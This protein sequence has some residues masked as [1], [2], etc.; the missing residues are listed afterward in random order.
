MP[1]EAVSATGESTRSMGLDLRLL[2]ESVVVVVVLVNVA[3]EMVMAGADG[4]VP[5]HEK[6]KIVTYLY[7]FTNLQVYM[8]IL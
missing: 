2:V 6:S 4:V 8:D 3:L 1:L 5:G 7:A